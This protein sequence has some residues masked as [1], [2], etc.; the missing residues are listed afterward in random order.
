MT[1]TKTPVRKSKPAPKPMSRTPPKGE[2]RPLGTK[3][4]TTP[5]HPAVA[6]SQA[7]TGNKGV[8][9]PKP[10][11]VARRPIATTLGDGVT[12]IDVATGTYLAH[13]VLA[14][15]PAL[16]FRQQELK[17]QMAP[18]E[19]LVAEEKAIRADIEALL[20]AAGVE[21]EKVTVGQFTI[22]RTEVDGAEF[23]SEDLL[24]AAGVDADIIKAAKDRHAAYSYASVRKAKAKG[25]TAT[26]G[27][28]DGEEAQTA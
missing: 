2:A 26:R 17:A 14:G 15:L 28:D 21:D 19:A 20:I 8:Q 12:D 27:E 22:S 9:G 23:L 7:K 6:R 13:P 3:K 1:K 10:V 24:L 18:L 25:Q 16:I 11:P 5:T 4:A